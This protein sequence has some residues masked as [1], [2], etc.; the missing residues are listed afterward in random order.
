M[1]QCAAPL[2]CLLL[3]NDVRKVKAAKTFILPEDEFRSS[4][5]SMSTIDIALAD[6]C[7]ELQGELHTACR[8]YVNLTRPYVAAET[9]RQRKLDPKVELKKFASGLVRAGL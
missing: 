1:S 9:F 7:K 2:V 3:R 6:R 8:R 5:L 4:E